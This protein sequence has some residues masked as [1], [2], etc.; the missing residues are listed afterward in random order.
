MRTANPPLGSAGPSCA[1][2]FLTLGF[3]TSM[4]AAQA[5][6]DLLADSHLSLEARNFYMNRDYRDDG[7][8]DHPRHD[9]Q[10]QGKAED[11]GQGFLLR[12]ASGFTEGTVGFGLDVLGLVGIKLDS[13]G[14][15]S[16][17]GALQRN[18][19][20]GEPVD[21]LSFLGPSA[22]MK[23]AKT[24]VTVGDHEPV[25]PV[26]YRNDTRLLPQTYQG[27]QVVS[28]DIQ[29]LNLTAGQFRQAHQRDSSDYEDLRMYS[30]SSRGGVA[31]DRFNYAGATYAFSPGLSATLYRAELKD[32][33]SQNAASLLYKIP[34][35]SG[36]N[37][38]ADI[39]YF[40]SDAQ[41]HT[42]VDNRFF[43]GMFTLSTQGHSLGIA[44][45]NQNGRTGLPFLLVADPWALNNGTYHHFVRAAEDSWQ[46]RYDYD[47]TAV[48]IPGLTLMTRYMRGDDFKVAGVDA[49]EWER[50]TD[51]GYVIQSG[52]LKNLSVRWRN[53]TYRGSDTT[54]V[55]EN[56]VI[57]GYTYRFW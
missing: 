3:S 45:Q 16:G 40:G 12:G 15:S 35:A 56:R 44:Y 2:F 38:K 34:L 4:L 5:H 49:K 21:E 20:T 36:L 55:D 41:G 19:L 54:N 47:F 14:G 26:L 43:G 30:D 18:R 1:R 28:S 39:R 22:K 46:L 8:F 11:W 51:I 42:N 13:G 31:T 33:Y 17:T 10:P 32:N 50:N 6:A 23:I 7:L 25:M 53:V 48:G 27:A 57:I 29:N 37:F 24:L 52:P 9:G